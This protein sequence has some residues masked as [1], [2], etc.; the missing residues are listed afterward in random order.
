MG[1][2]AFDA[3]LAVALSAGLYTV[4]YTTR[5]AWLSRANL[6]EGHVSAA[7]PRRSRT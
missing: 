5:L 7:D 6:R 3:P 1:E 2:D 4:Y